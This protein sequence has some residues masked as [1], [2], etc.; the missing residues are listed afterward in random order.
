MRFH[1]WLCVCVRANLEERQ[2]KPPLWALKNQAS[3]VD[4]KKPIKVVNYLKLMDE[5]FPKCL[6]NLYNIV[7][8]N[9]YSYP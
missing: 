6:D 1:M 2:A 3:I 8:Y 4:T 9:S 7:D 5:W